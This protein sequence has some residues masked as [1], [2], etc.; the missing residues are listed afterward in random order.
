MVSDHKV[1]EG[2]VSVVIGGG[3]LGGGRDVANEGVNS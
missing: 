1:G 3:G 2:G